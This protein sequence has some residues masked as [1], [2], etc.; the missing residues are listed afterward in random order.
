MKKGVMLVNMGGP[1]SPAELKVFLSRMFRD[2]FILPFGRVARSM[3][4]FLISNT[5]YRTSW[6]KYEL[7]GGTPLVRSTR[8]TAAALQ[9]SL[10]NKWRVKF[11]FSYSAPLISSCL[12]EFKQEGISYVRVIP[13]YPQASF[14]T[15]GSVRADLQKAVARDTFFELSV[16]PE[17]Y[18]HPGFTAFWTELIRKHVEAAGLKNPTLVFSAHSIPEYNIKNGDTYAEAIVNSAASIATALGMHYEAG[19]QSGLKRGKWIGPDIRELIKTLREEEVDNL[20]MIPIS[21]LDENLETLYDLDQEL[22]PWACSLGFTNVSRVRLPEADPLLVS[23]LAD[24]ALNE[25]DI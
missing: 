17:F 13:V 3:F 2:P 1:E 14:T 7:I 10:G 8:A 23:L 11:A 20:V 15:T 21:F 5:R 9:E 25:A 24:L 22:I 4:S 6:K 16:V 12:A 18:R 19:F